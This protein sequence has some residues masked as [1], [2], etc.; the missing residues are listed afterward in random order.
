MKKGYVYTFSN[1]LDNYGQVLQYLAIQTFLGHLD[2]K[3]YILRYKPQHS[4]SFPKL[5]Y[6]ALNYRLQLLLK[7]I[8]RRRGKHLSSEEIMRQFFIN[9]L[10]ETKRQEKLHPRYF[11]EFRTKYFNIEYYF[12]LEKK[13]PIADA[14]FVGSDQVWGYFTKETMLDFGREETKRIAFAPSFGGRKPLNKKQWNSFS[15]GLKRFD[16]VTVR[17]PEG[18]EYCKQAG[19]HN[20]YCIPDPTLLLTEKDYLPFI[21]KKND[22]H[23]Q[24]YILIYLLGNNTNIKIDEI[25]EFANKHDL[26]VKYVVSQGR[27][28]QYEK[29]FCTIPEWLAIIKEAKYIFTNSFHG[30]AFA[31]TFHRPFMVFPLVWP[32]ERMNKRIYNLLE[33]Y[34]L[35]SKIYNGDLSLILEPID[36]NIIERIKNA[37]TQKIYKLFNNILNK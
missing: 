19:Y 25:Y 5:V 26:D 10:K 37:E 4:E 22:Y 6:R 21:D 18:I 32:F 27:I 11:E 7:K 33:K 1:T 9:A 2:Y 12:D 36:Y 3:T 29:T 30:T 17:E 16:L 31:I 35:S 15:N 14:Y 13:P 24:N 8:Y 28:D 23:N 34:N 20:A